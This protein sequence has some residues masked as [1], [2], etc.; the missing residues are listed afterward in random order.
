[1][2]N[3]DKEV[4]EGLLIKRFPWCVMKSTFYPNAAS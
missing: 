4:D 3:E 1:M 2:R